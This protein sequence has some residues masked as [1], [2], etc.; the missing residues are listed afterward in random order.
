MKNEFRGV[1][2]KVECFYKRTD[3]RWGFKTHY[4]VITVVNSVTNCEVRVVTPNLAS[5][6]GPRWKAVKDGDEI[7][8]RGVITKASN[9]PEWIM[10]QSK[11]LERRIV[12][13][14]QAVPPPQTRTV[15][16]MIEHADKV[17]ELI[18]RGL[19]AGKEGYAELCDIEK[20]AV[21]VEKALE[22]LQAKLVDHMAYAAKKASK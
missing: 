6:T 10:T 14:V 12:A 21:A 15:M 9:G 7:L 20:E 2:Q 13:S 11:L 3:P 22:T 17:V 19:K 16:D 8:V 4:L 5:S 18:C 1:V